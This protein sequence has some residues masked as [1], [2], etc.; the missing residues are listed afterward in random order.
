MKPNPKSVRLW[1]VARMYVTGHES[2][3]IGR[4]V[5]VNGWGEAFFTIRAIENGVCHLST[6]YKKSIKYRQPASK[7]W[8]TRRHEKEILKCRPTK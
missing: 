1:G 8:F 3:A 4:E 7:C 5:H 2:N 6:R